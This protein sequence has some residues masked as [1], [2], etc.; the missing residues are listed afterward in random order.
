[1]DVNSKYLEWEDKLWKK[2]NKLFPNA[3]YTITDGVISPV[4]YAKAPFRVMIL[5]RE[6]YDRDHDSYSLNLEGILGDIQTGKKVF[7][8]QRNLRTRLKEYLGTIDYL[9]THNFKAAELELRGYINNLVEDDFNHNLLKCAYINIKKSDGV[10]PSTKANLREYTQQGLEILKEQIS[11][12]NPSVI[13]AGD[14]CDDIL[15][16]LMD[17]EDGGLYNFDGSHA[18]KV[19][20]LKIG[21][22]LFPY[23]D[24]YHPARTKEYT[25][26]GEYHSMKDLYL[27][28]SKAIQQIEKENLGFWEKRLDLPCF[29]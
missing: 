9:S 12:M 10:F 13:L 1:M 7:C 15:D 25:E 22:Q 14:V 27:E 24:M 26:N 3:T 20:Q 5:N 2:Y 18:I 6:A 17:W 8:R 11:F 4:D 28:L 19:Y 21:D 29:E 16:P 23:F